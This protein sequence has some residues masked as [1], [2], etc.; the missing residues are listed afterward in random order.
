MFFR[1]DGLLVRAIVMLKFEE[2]DP[3]A[4]WFADQLCEVAFR[5]GQNGADIV[6]SVPLHKVRRSRPSCYSNESLNG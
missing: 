6:V 3:L 1:Y 5:S 4:D 2:M